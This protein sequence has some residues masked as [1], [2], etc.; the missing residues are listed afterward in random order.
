MTEKRWKKK[1]K[2]HYLGKQMQIDGSWS[3]LVNDVITHSTIT[4]DQSKHIVIE[5][6]SGDDEKQRKRTEL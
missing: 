2:V 5:K 6:G 3:V 1:R 4:F